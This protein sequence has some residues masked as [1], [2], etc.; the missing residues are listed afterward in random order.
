MS[1][2]GAEDSKRDWRIYAEFWLLLAT[3]L[4]GFAALVLL[5]AAP[6]EARGCGTS[7]YLNVQGRCVHRPVQSSSM[8]TGATA[9]CR[10]GTYSFSQNHRGTCSHHGGVARWL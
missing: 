1:D 5:L 6:A 4:V 3:W 10:D 8:P 7:S 2:W 9:Q